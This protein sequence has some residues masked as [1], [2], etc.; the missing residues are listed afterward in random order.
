MSV[1]HGRRA[2]RRAA[3]LL[4]LASLM[5]AIAATGAFTQP[6]G[7]DI[8]PAGQ[9]TFNAG[10][11][12]GCPLGAVACSSGQFSGGLQ[13]PYEVVLTTLLPSLTP[14]VVFASGRLVLHTG[15]GDLRCDLSGAFNTGATSQGEWGG[16][17]VLT[18]GTGAYRQTRGHIRMYG[19]NTP[20]P[21]IIP[22][23]GGGDYT[24]TIVT[25]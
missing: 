25:T 11:L 24:A 18:A 19:L 23:S 14:N 10:L 4:G 6:A 22:S 5:T 9:Y 12:I 16:I 15:T 13:G 3:A 17:C 21:L 20:G 8:H 7:A 2:P 1:A